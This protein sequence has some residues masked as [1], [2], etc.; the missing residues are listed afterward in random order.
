MRLGRRVA[1]H[2]L[3]DRHAE[4]EINYEAP[5]CILARRH[6]PAAYSYYFG[7]RTA[8]Y[9]LHT[10][11][12]GQPDHRR[13]VD[14]AIWG[15]PIVNF[16]AMRQAYFRDAEA[17]YNDIIWWPKGSGWKN[18]SLTVNTSVRYLY[19]FSNT[20]EDGPTVVDLP[21]AVAGAS[22][23]GTIEDAWFLPLV[24]IGFE[25]K[26]GKYLILPP[27]Y[28]AE[29]PP[30]FIPLRPK[31]YNTMTLV[32][33]ILA[34]S[35]EDDVRKG[36]ELVKQV[37]IYP[38]A[39]ADNPPTQRFVEMTD[40]I[41]D[42]LVRYDESLYTSLARMLN[43]EPVQPRDL[44]MMGMILPL[45]IEKGKEFKPD[46][47]TVAQLKVAAK[48]AH[49]WLNEQLANFVTDRTTSPWIHAASRLHRFS[50][51]PR[52]SV[53]AAFIWRR[54]MT[55]AV[56]HC[57]AKILIGCTSPQTFRCASSGLLRYTPWKRRRSSANSN[58][59][60]S[61]RLTRGCAKTPMGRW[62][63]TLDRRRQPDRN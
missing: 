46:A 7:F 57:G 29:V 48:E 27:D 11:G 6:R 5:P 38:L 40:T 37:K 31:T 24:D 30:G 35:S 8:D 32:R 43:E 2:Q 21:P 45:G 54:I 63:S 26:G 44:Q 25:G 51:Q 42:G 20:R 58:A 28:K 36:D 13:A 3:A 50:P 18:Q 47:A 56:N 1:E 39:K 52:S 10:R 49:A 23:Y 61:A 14:A 15:M 60:R 12:F 62:T 34:S 41:Y 17:K 4:R 19:V 59:S 33:S 53:R 9:I 16:D 22:F 55:A